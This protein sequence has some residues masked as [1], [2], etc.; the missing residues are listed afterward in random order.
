MNG[1]EHIFV[2]QYFGFYLCVLTP[3]KF[4]KKKNLVTCYVTN[5][6][7]NVAFYSLPTQQEFL[8]GLTK[9]TLNRQLL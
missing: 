2:L 9:S 6:F 3:F 7:M 8:V 5:S 1:Y 4:K